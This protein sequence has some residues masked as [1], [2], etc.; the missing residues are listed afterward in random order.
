[1]VGPA[2]PLS[3]PPARRGPLPVPAGISVEVCADHRG[4]AGGS[5]AAADTHH[6]RQAPVSLPA[7]VGESWRETA[8][9][10]M[11]GFP[12]LTILDIIWPWRM[13]A[14]AFLPASVVIEW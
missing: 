8:G 2:I 12:S 13:L 4:V 7:T 6:A 10:S 11:Y 9:N 14:E 5:R 3:G 1:M